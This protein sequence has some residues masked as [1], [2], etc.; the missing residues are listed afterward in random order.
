[1]VF[2]TIQELEDRSKTVATVRKPFFWMLEPQSLQSSHFGK[3]LNPFQPGFSGLLL[4]LL[5]GPLPRLPRFEP[6][7][8]SRSG[9]PA[10]RKL[11]C[12][13]ND[14][15]HKIPHT[16]EGQPA[17]PIQGSVCG[18]CFGPSYHHPARF[19]RSVLYTLVGNA[20]R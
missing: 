20:R 2:A 16:L 17:T 8:N 11:E 12:D 10:S 5:F 4:L 7:L 13:G 15:E 6:G 1:M 3:K 9:R 18:P 14:Q 19:T